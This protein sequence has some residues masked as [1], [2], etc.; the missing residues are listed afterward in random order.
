MFGP[1]RLLVQEGPPVSAWIESSLQDA[2]VALTRAGN[3]DIA[4]SLGRLL[5]EPELKMLQLYRNPQVADLADAI[6]D[7]DSF[8]ALHEQ[9]PGVAAAFG[10][11]HC[12]IH[13]V[14]ERTAAFLPCKVLT[15]FPADWIAEYVQKRYST[16]DPV[17]A[18][19]LRANGIFFWDEIDHP[20]PAVVA[21]MRAAA[22]HGVGPSGVTFT[23]DNVHGNTVAVSLA[24]PEEPDVFRRM[25][26]PR[27]SDF[28]DLGGL[29]IE[30]FSDIGHQGEDG[31]CGTLTDDQL[32]VLRAVAAG[33]TAT[34]MEAFHFTYG[35]FATIEKSILMNMRART[36]AQA[37]VFAIKHGLLEDLP[38]Y[39]EDIFGGRDLRVPFDA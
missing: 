33:R 34:E 19:S 23:A 4:A 11:V 7:T 38:Y 12:T 6:L 13:C 18:R 30:V 24:A 26:T 8:E 39:E 35:S 27:L 3:G 10:A 22:G 31:P 21:F 2:I 1:Y 17:I 32:K 16:I 9:L 20:S 36:L 25:F 29:L 28:S 15:T 5:D 37:A 14:R